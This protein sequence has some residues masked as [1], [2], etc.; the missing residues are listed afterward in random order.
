MQWILSNK[1]IHDRGTRKMS[2]NFEVLARLCNQAILLFFCTLI[3]TF[4]G[5]LLFGTF[6]T[7][8]YYM[9]GYD[10]YRDSYKIRYAKN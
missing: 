2:I 8:V 9:L 6:I 1:N 7:I 5:Y 10:D 3:F 4:E